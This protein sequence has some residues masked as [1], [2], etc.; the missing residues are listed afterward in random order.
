MPED[1]GHVG[2][3]LNTRCDA[4]VLIFENKFL[5]S[6]HIQILYENFAF[7]VYFPVYPQTVYQDKIFLQQSS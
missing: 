4:T 7:K 6:K 1:W 3:L 5:N 2:Q